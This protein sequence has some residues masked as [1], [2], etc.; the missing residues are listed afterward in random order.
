MYGLLRQSLGG[1]AQ[2]SSVATPSTRR[3][4]WQVVGR[5]VI[6]LGITSLLTDISSEMVSAILPL[7]LLYQLQAT[8]LQ[9][10]IVDGLYQGAS[11]LVRIGAA[12]TADRWQR[13]KEVAST[14]Y[15]L[16]AFSRF[17]L[18]VFG[19]AVQGV[20]G[21]VLVDR[22]GKGIRTAPLDALISLSVP[23]ERLGLAFG[24]HR[25]LDTAGSLIGPLLA[26]GLL[27]LAPGAFDAVF[28][29]SLCIGLLG[30]A[31][32]VLFVN[33]PERTLAPS[34]PPDLHGCARLLTCRASVSW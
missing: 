34:A 11:G 4:T 18:L 10:G 29:P 20:A 8:A 17:G 16:S 21:F 19:G 31:V 12:L 33:N 6:F 27:T 25:T 24:V 26:F 5:T 32:I 13:Q 7:Y 28:M 1:I 22:F 14:G 23:R 30:L 15:A 9:L 3:L 2:S